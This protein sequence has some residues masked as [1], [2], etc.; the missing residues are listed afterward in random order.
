MADHHSQTIE[1][2]LDPDPAGW[3]DTQRRLLLEAD[4]APAR[5]TLAISGILPKAVEAWLRQQVAAEAPWAESD[6]LAYIK[7]REE[8]WLASAD[9]EALGLLTNEIP[10]KLA[11]APGC[12]RWAEAHWGHRLENLFLRHKD[13]LDQASCRLL[14]VS[15]K[16]LAL[17]LY[18]RIKAG[19]DSFE[20]L[21]QRFG[22][23]PERQQGGLIPLQP[24]ASLP[25]GLNKVL[26]RLQPGELLQPTRLGKQVALVQ[27]ESWQP[28]RLD[29]TSRKRLLT[30][31][32]DQWLKATGALALAH[33]RC[34]D[35]I[36]AVIP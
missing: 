32:L 8:A 2:P 9:P 21:A 34:P 14:R 5:A 20:V 36:E 35:R 24:L 19:E 28:A 18:H 3:L 29:A 6:R 11:V 23:G 1:A 31:E 15:D 7:E 12:L 33:L 10:L 30:A 17:E 26:P 13:E 27:L 16:G 4:F 25:L 22:E